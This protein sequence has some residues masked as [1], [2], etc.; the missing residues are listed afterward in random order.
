MKRPLLAVS[1]VF[2]G[3]ILLG[4]WLDARFWQGATFS[5]TAFFG[6]LF[7]QRHRWNGVCLYAA[8]LGA[9]CAAYA[10]A[11]AI[12]SPKHLRN[13]VVDGRS[14]NVELRG[15]IV[16]D[17]REKEFATNNAPSPAP[18]SF[19]EIADDSAPPD[20]VDF[21]LQA[22][23]I[24]LRGEW[25]EAKGKILVYVNTRGR[26]DAFEYGQQL[27]CSALL[28][29]PDAPRNPGMFDFQ[30]YLANQGIH[31]VA[32]VRQ[33]D[34][35]NIERTL[36]G[37]L[38]VSAAY[39]LRNRLREKLQ[40]GLFASPVPSETDTRRVAGLLSGML[41]GYRED[42]PPELRE[43][44]T[45]TSAMHVFAISGLHVGMMATVLFF[46]LRLLRLSRQWSAA[47]TVPLLLFYVTMTGMRPSAVRAFVMTAVFIACW[48]WI[49]PSDAL[50]SLGAAA[51]A[52]LAFQP[53]QL[54]DGGF[55]MS[56]AVVA[57]II[58]CMPLCE[59][60]FIQRF[61]ADAFLPRESFSAWR[62]GFDKIWIPLARYFA[63]TV[64]AWIGSAPFIAYY[65]NLISPISLVSN[66][67]VVFLAF[68]MVAT[69]FVAAVASLFSDWLVVTLNNANLFF[70]VAM[71][72]VV[73]WLSQIPW[74]YFYIKPPSAWLMMTYYAAMLALMTGWVFRKRVRVFTAASASCM[75]IVFLAWTHLPQPDEGT[76]TFLD[77]GSGSAVFVDLPGGANDTLVDAGRESAARHI[78]APFLRR[79]GLNEVPR[80]VITQWDINHAGGLAGLLPRFKVREI[81]ESGWRNPSGR[82][83][84]QMLELSQREEIPLRRAV[85]GDT[86]PLG[87]YSEIRVLHPPSATKFKTFDDNSM[88]VHLRIG[89]VRILLMSDAGESVEK[90]LVSSNVDL[91]SEIL[92]LGSHARETMGTAEFLDRVGASTVILHRGDPWGGK[93]APSDLL[94]RLKE[95]NVTVFDTAQHGAVIVEVR[96]NRAKIKSVLSPP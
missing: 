77:V 4:W 96:N 14:Q 85:A 70:G 15:R 55:Q 90:L 18:P 74:G 47:A 43:S 65:F 72:R 95:R 57:S 84:K 37:N 38:V 51:L 44:F 36:Q 69:G 45:R 68:C 56:F 16:S 54:F 17:P 53:L 73:D 5:L 24:K 50:N 76:V 3:G 78:I 29:V 83:Q 7:T 48:I 75:V 12:P 42:I 19:R 60:F 27:Y 91:K 9:G 52:V 93:G 58:I 39:R 26:A 66:V 30:S 35:C 63:L 88:V 62:R 59:K 1:L 40:D 2:A 81:V 87:D 8:V 33:R 13:L 21:V 25:R 86:V 71:I 61:A 92:V 23:A 11:T 89:G 6:Y 32:R 10:Y 79:N 22:T 67:A 46:A 20:R 82:T 49:R 31:F 34:F 28:Q 41:L 94:E 80:L 64:A